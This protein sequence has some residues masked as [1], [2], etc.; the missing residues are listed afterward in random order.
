[1][2]VQG[3]LRNKV[4]GRGAIGLLVAAALVLFAPVAAATP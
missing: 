1:M 4:L 2:S 3:I